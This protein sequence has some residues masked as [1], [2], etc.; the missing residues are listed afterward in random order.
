MPLPSEANLNDARIMK[1]ALDTDLKDFLQPGNDCFAD[2]G[3]RDVK[4]DLEN[5]DFLVCMPICLGGNKQFTATQANESRFVTKIRWA[6]ELSNTKRHHQIKVLNF[7]LQNR[8]KMLP[9]IGIMLRIACHITNMYGKRLSSS[10][11]MHDEVVK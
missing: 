7:C 4:G 5:M 11:H 8:Y 10:R 6:V 1:W 3:F 9:K 2:R